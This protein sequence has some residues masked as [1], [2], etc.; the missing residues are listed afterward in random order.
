M[1]IHVFGI[2]HHGP[3]CARSLLSA[4]RELQPDAVLLEAPADVQTVL[5]LADH[6]E[7]RPPVALLL[8]PPDEPRRSVIFPLAVFSPEWQ[9]LQFALAQR[10]PVRAMDLPISHRMTLVDDAPEEPKQIPPSSA[11]ESGDGGGDSPAWRT[12][13]IALLAQAAGYADHE[14]WWEEQVE[15]RQDA[16]GLFAAILEAMRAVRAE[17]PQTPERDLLREAFMRKSIRAAVKE[18]FARIAVVCGAWHAPVLDDA[19]I[20]GRRGGCTVKEDTARLKGLSKCKTVAT[21]IPWTHS[22]LAYRSGYGAGVSSPGW[23]AHLWESQTDAPTR[24]LVTAA[25]L[26]RAQDLNASSANVIEARR[27]ADALAALR[28]LRSPGLRELNEAILS[29]LCHG[30]PSP[31]RLIHRRLEIGDCLGG[32]P[33]ETHAVPLLQDLQ[34]QQKS[35]RLKASPERRVLDL[36]LRQEQARAR[37]W[38]LHRLRILG[39]S[40]GEPLEA[41][42]STSTFHELWDLQW[43]PEFAILLV[44]ASLWGNTIVQASAARLVD[45]AE[46]AKSLAETSEL[47]VCALR[48][49]LQSTIA[50]LLARIQSMSAVSTDVVHLMEALPALARVSRYGDVRGTSAQMLEPILIGILERIIAGL[51]PACSALD[52]ESAERLVSAL[53][54]SQTALDLLP[55]LSLREEW[56]E[57]LLQLTRERIHGLVRGWCCRRLFEQRRLSTDDL[58]RL[59]RQALSPATATPQAAAWVTGLLRG[60]GLLLLHQD[61]LW[62]VMDHWLSGLPEGTFL[63]TLPVLRRAFAGFTPAERRQMGV[64]VRHLSSSGSTV[65]E[66][67]LSPVPDINQE[68]A[69]RVLPVLAQILG[70]RDDRS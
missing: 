25:R 57:R 29:V 6:P 34:Q 12:D 40:W 13:P 69:A 43:Q 62:Q 60:S 21:W 54:Q 66:T 32:V 58:D 30:D 17:V 23:Y 48:A 33:R 38:L 49:D 42:T 20:A 15:R 56:D 28:D 45:G 41:R 8:Y 50:P 44:E 63:E 52:D 19:A 9:A 68:R 46:K 3:G 1:S 7:L 26:L 51:A 2:R 65:V 55:Q 27:L 35:L 39:V 16:A 37:S 22:R 47:L 64:K 61:A 53:E 14:L 36:D 31:L 70:V 18:G 24:W 4:L 10:V 5:P 67:S 59:T 11:P